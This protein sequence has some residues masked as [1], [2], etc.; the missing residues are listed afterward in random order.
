MSVLTSVLCASCLSNINI[1]FNFDN[2]HINVKSKIYDTSKS[3]DLDVSNFKID[4]SLKLKNDLENGSNH[5]AFSYSKK[6]QDLDKNFIYLLQN[7][8]PNIK[9][10]CTY[11]INTN[12]PDAYKKIYENTSAEV[13]NI[14]FLA[15]KNFII[16]SKK[17]KNITI[18]TY[19]LQSKDEHSIQYLNKSIEYIKDYEKRIGDYPYK[20]FKIVENI[21]QTG[22]SM[23]T[24]TLIGSRLLTKPYILKQSL[25]HEILH[26]YFGSSI[27]NDF[28][29]GNWVE[30]L[31]TYLADD[32][33]KSLQNEGLV[34][35]K[36]ILSE[37]E[38]LVD[39]EKDFPINNFEYRHDKASMLIGYSKFSFVF[40]MLEK[41][42]GHTKFLEITKNLYQTYKNKELNLKEMTDFFQK[43]TKK[44]LKIFFEQWLN[45]PG[46]LDFKIENAKNYFN[47]DGFWLSFDVS[48]DKDS[49]YS[50]DLRVK[51]NTYD[52]QKFET[53]KITKPTQNIKLNFPSEILSVTFDENI[54]LFRKLTSKEK[55]L[56][57]SSL[58][59]QKDMIAVVNKNDLN[60]YSDIKKIFPSIKVVINDDLKFKDLKQNS[61]VFLDFDNELLKQFY[62]YI[63]Q[64]KNSSYISV[65][66]HVYNENKQMAVLHFGEVKKRYLLMLK[67][68]SKYQEII[69]S[70]N[71]TVKNMHQSDNGI[72]LEFNKIP[73]LIKVV[74]QKNIKDIF[75]QLKDK[76]VVYVGESHD[77]FAHHLNQLRVI[78]SLHENG[79]KVSIGMEMFQ[80]PFQTDLDEYI[81]GKTTLNEFLK[82]SEYFKRWKFDYNLYKPILDYA[83]K[84]K[85]KVVALNIDRNITQHVSKNGLFSLLEKQKIKLP[86]QIDQSNL[87]YKKSLDNIF[88]GHI[89][90]SI[91]TKIN[92]KNKH[93]P[94]KLN[95]DF[96]YQ[97]QL[98]WDE[99]MAENIDNFIKNDKNTV[100]VVIVGSGHIL[101][102]HGIPSRVYKRN[103][104]PYKV[105]L[106]NENT[107]KAD[108]IILLNK[109]KTKIEKQNRIGVYL[110]NSEELIATRIVKKSFS[111]K[112][113]VK[114]GDLIV[115][116]NSQSVEDLYDL[117]RV[118]YFVDN[119]NTT[120]IKVKRNGKVKQLKIEE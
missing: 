120:T 10:R 14:S 61:I 81:E 66:P 102:H 48:Q 11:K 115:E 13:D 44:D 94:T 12:L 20:E 26:Q 104:L 23:P 76:R 34:N 84:N 46:I 39:K 73:K 77:N 118:L 98:I 67:Y 101:E 103:N 1:D 85:I 107:T 114:K 110:K 108:D 79:K 6:V 58:L 8:Y 49:F 55:L 16:K 113:G 69:L 37:F 21:H 65:Q 38:N 42:I 117:K 33:Y 25:A 7:W 64:N 56:S 2:K 28:K 57:I 29:K 62:P 78:K 4:N 80:K 22:Y 51:I 50:F 100:M 19:F 45:K 116:L 24:F 63:K 71:K 18:K 32:Y 105:I 83:R 53:L 112:V 9:G 43:N 91:P 35:R 99:I 97:S 31:T 96:F 92:T 68:Y 87:V 89:P 30:A 40:Y 88:K 60:K 3:I 59:N 106:N 70:K 54:E 47:K 93:A 90:K 86:K 72:T 75:T 74:E 5:V 15:S 36:T 111:S 109:T 52:N 41:K 95:L 82:N 17:Y 119:L 27:S